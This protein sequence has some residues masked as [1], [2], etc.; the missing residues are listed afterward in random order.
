MKNIFLTGALVAAVAVGGTFVYLQQNGQSDTSVASAIG[1]VLVPK[2]LAQSADFTYEEYSQARFDDLEGNEA[3]AVFVHSKTCGT[4]AKKN[5]QIIDEVAAF[6][7]GMILKMEY[8]DA[9]QSFLAEH[10]VTKYDTFVIFDAA[11]N[12]TTIKGADVAEV[13]DAL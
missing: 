6:P 8:S 7:S 12:A 10:G 5:N 2:V 9:P 11:G 13:R 1:D 3:F 4:C